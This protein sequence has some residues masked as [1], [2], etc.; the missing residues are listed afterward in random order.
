[1]PESM[2]MWVEIGFNITYLIVIWGLVVVMILQRQQVA[3]RD[4]PAARS[5]IWA[6]A[7][8]ALGDTGHV[9]FRVV[10]YAMGTLESTVNV[11]GLQLG[12]VGLGA[13]STAITVTIFYMLMLD[14]W[15]KR[16]NRR[17]G[18]FEYSLL[19]A[20]VFRLVFMLLPVNQWNSVVPP[21]PW[22]TIRNLP[23][24]LLGLGVAYLFLRDAR[25]AEDRTFQWIGVMILVSYAC[26]IPVILFVQQV[27]MIGMLM[28]PKT[29]AYVAIGFL[30]YR[31]LYKLGSIQAMK[32]TLETTI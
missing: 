12:L 31:D 21:Q 30:A 27:P 7:L 17:F 20:G 22:S 24:M 10:A 5:I 14:V 16:F 6:F 32:P 1:M 13:L 2:R 4:W 18:W 19:V 11:L 26:Y 23:L 28:I 3:E 15:R 8:L 29:M 25:P 9:G